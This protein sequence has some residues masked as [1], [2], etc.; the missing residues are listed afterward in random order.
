MK[1]GVKS[2]IINKNI[3]AV[4]EDLIKLTEIRGALRSNEKFEVFWGNI[5]GNNF[6]F[7]CKNSRL[8]TPELRGELFEM[9]NNE[10]LIR[11]DIIFST[12][13]I[14]MYILWYIFAIYMFFLKLLPKWSGNSIYHNIFFVIFL[15]F[16]PI[17]LFCFY[18]Y[19]LKNMMDNFYIYN[20]G[21]YDKYIKNN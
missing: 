21:S 1:I 12:F 10:T 13:E 2:L 7:Y 15:F 3:N 16:F 19:N 17:V 4:K 14:M 5:T 20:E 11:I 9:N 18:L 6:I 8:Q